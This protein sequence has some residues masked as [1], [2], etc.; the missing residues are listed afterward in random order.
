MSEA[1]IPARKFLRLFDYLE[2]LE[3]D[4]ASIAASANLS[5]YHWGK[6]TA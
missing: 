3:L 4:V 1:T 2:H 6:L 5:C